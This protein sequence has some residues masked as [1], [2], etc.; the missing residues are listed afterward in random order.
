MHITRGEFPVFAGFVD[1]GEK[2]LSLFLPGDI[3]PEF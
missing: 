3:Q 1:P 2:A